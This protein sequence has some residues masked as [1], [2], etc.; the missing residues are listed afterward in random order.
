MTRVVRDNNRKASVAPAV[1]YQSSLLSKD[2][3]PQWDIFWQVPQTFPAKLHQIVCGFVDRFVSKIIELLITLYLYKI[4][5][6][7]SEG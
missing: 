4:E 2:M 7:N 6:A 5:V 3:T 1:V